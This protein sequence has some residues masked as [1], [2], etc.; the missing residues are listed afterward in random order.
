MKPPVDI[1]ILS[2]NRSWSLTQTV[3]SI[4]EWTD[5]PY[6]ISIQDHGSE[7]QERDHLRE[8]CAPDCR[9]ICLDTFLSCNEGRRRGLGLVD[10]PFVV[11]LDDDVRVGRDWL[12][13]L[14][15][16]LLPRPACA[17]VPMNLCTDGKKLESGVRNFRDGE[18]I[19][20]PHGYLGLGRAC[21]G[22]ATLYRSEA[23]R[24]TEFRAEYNAGYEDWD[25]TLQMTKAGWEVW[26]SLS[27]GHHTHQSDSLDYF[28]DRWRWPEFLDAA[29][30]LHRRWGISSGIR[31]VAAHMLKSGLRIRADQWDALKV[32]GL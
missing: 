1:L 31:R 20:E 29:I 4:R 27:Y 21:L 32:A 17:A 19:M 23:L 22:G 16:M 18:V 24:Q 25:Q 30:G 7:P 10:S 11:F 12:D 26:G 14:M 9:L 3:G 6:R 5:W 2:R 13:R 28:P 15:E 8:L